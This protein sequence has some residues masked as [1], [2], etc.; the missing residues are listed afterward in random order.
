MLQGPNQQ[1]M[2]YVNELSR[3]TE[4]KASPTSERRLTQIVSQAVRA[5]PCVWSRVC[6][7][8]CS[9]WSRPCGHAAFRLPAQAQVT[10][11]NTPVRCAGAAER[12]QCTVHIPVQWRSPRCWQCG[13][14]PLEKHCGASPHASIS[15]GAPDIF[16][17][18]D[19]VNLCHLCA[20]LPARVRFLCA[21]GI[22]VVIATTDLRT[23]V[24]R[25]TWESPQ[26]SGRR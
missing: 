22:H 3:L 1:W 14:R 17:C 6:L 13:P 24:H 26:S 11:C 2:E 15:A 12:T 9:G 5:H 10:G 4:D 16:T 18:C 25:P 8:R 19:G 21:R 20:R 7:C 23:C